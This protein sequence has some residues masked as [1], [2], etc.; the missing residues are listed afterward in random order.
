MYMLTLFDLFQ[1]EVEEVMILSI[2]ECN[3]SQIHSYMV[4][5]FNRYA[6]YEVLWN[7]LDEILSR[8]CKKFETFG[9]FCRHGLKVFDVLDIKLIPNRYIMN[10]WRRDV[11]DGS[12]KDCT[13]HN[14]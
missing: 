8:N 7:P 13:R 6:K 3:V 14:S 4:G 5:V 11:K 2:L 12:E 10:R 9:I 1:I